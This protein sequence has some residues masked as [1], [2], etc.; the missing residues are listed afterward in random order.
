MSF[1]KGVV[2]KTTVP[3]VT[4]DDTK[5]FYKGFNWIFSSAGA[6]VTYECV[7]DATGAAV[8]QATSS[9]NGSGN[10]FQVTASQ[11]S[12]TV[13]TT[14]DLRL[15]TSATNI[16]PFIIP[17]VGKLY[18]MSASSGSAVAGRDWTAEVFKNG[19]SVATLTLTALAKNQRSD[20]GVSFAAGDEVRLVFTHT[21]G[22]VNRPKITAF[23][24]LD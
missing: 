23:F 13:N 8:W 19:V 11:N 16:S 6:L 17:K 7:S 15:G 18:A 10:T 20:L 22:N 2:V 12:N 4:D 3:G 1:V 24:K 9:N 21:S 5:G 14:R